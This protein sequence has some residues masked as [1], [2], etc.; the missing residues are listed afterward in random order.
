MSLTDRIEPTLSSTP[1]PEPTPAEVSIIARRRWGTALRRAARERWGWV[2]DSQQWWFVGVLIAVTVLGCLLVRYPHQVP[3][4]VLII[5]AVVAGVRLQVKMLVAVFAYILVW[6][7][8]F[9]VLLHGQKD[10]LPLASLAVVVVMGILLAS[11]I[12]RARLGLQGASSATLLLDLRDRL[13]AHG[14]LPRLPTSWSGE[15][16]LRSAH[17]E[18]F[19]G[20]F[21]VTNLSA[22]GR[23][24]EV[25]VVD[26]SGKGSD[27]GSRALQL[28]G[29]FSGM[30]G[31]LP[32]EEFLPAANGYLLR[33]HWDEG[34]ATAS[35][36]SLDLVTGEAAVTSAG[37]PPAVRFDASAGLWHVMGNRPGPLLGVISD[38]S[39][40][41]ANITLERGDA[42]LLYTDG[43]IEGRT[44][45]LVDGIDRL[46]GIAE[47]KVP[48]G[49]NGLAERLCATARGGQGDDRAVVVLWRN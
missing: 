32:P 48:T 12:A 49:L 44:T 26:V 43:V 46:A 22:D 15:V 14:Q 16:E 39:F 45:R 19:S 4:S 27:A 9:Y 38:V 17:G 41:S 20:D 37:H 29:A 8:V 24:L 42:V 25:T 40:T 13:R 23:L 34:F 6:L 18:G 1:L 5:C 2:V 33:Q 35:H 10:A 47:A 3:V 36:I 31:S 11:A 30:Q 28:Q 7:V 21:V